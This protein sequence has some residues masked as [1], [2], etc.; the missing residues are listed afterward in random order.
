MMLSPRWSLSAATLVAW[1]VVWSVNDDAL[2]RASGAMPVIPN[3]LRSPLMTPITAVPW[4]VSVPVVP[5]M[6]PP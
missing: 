6:T 2:I 1:D 4:F 5:A 3:P